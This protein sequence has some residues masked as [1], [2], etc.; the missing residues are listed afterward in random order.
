MLLDEPGE[1]WG[2]K[3]RM[4]FGGQGGAILILV[5]VLGNQLDDPGEVAGVEP[6]KKVDRGANVAAVAFVG[7]VGVAA[8][9]RAPAGVAD[10]VPFGEGADHHG[11]LGRQTGQ[12]A[13]GPGAQEGKVLIAGRQETGGHQQAADVGGGLPLRL[14]VQGFVVEH[15]RLADH[16]LQ[17]VRRRAAP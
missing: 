10:D 12:G 8:A 6:D 4:I 5:E 2:E 11:M 7:G 17:Q 1:D 9:G 14:R 13:S 15:V 3:Q 16:L